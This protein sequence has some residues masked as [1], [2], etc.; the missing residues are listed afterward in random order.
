MHNVRSSNHYIALLNTIASGSAS[1]GMSNFKTRPRY[2]ISPH[3]IFDFELLMLEH[4]IG[5][6]ITM[7]FLLRQ[8]KVMNLPELSLLMKYPML[9]VK[10]SHEHDLSK[11]KQ[12]PEFVERYYPPNSEASLSTPV[13]RY[14]GLD[15]RSD[16]VDLSP[17][18]IH[19][20]KNAF[21]ALNLVDDRLLEDL[22]S[23]Y[24]CENSVSMQ[25]TEQLRIQLDLFEHMADIL[26]RKLFENIM[27]FRRNFGNQGRQQ[28]VLEFGRPIDLSSNDPHHWAP[29]SQTKELALE[30]YYSPSL[31]LALSSIDTL[32]ISV[33][34]VA[35]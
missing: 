21:K 15:I 10:R 29:D 33:S 24:C 1:N 16:I 17:H 2:S 25:E 27:R 13:Y 6:G 8:A 31:R 5:V 9:V 28:E 14:Y 23:T 32:T 22:I 35:A 18:E 26:N 19:E 12:N 30:F 11:F 7:R 3:N 20:A 34:P 4:S